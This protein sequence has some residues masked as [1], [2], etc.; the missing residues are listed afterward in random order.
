MKF[1]LI[2][3]VQEIDVPKGQ[4]LKTVIHVNFSYLN[5]QILL[6]FHGCPVQVLKLIASGL[7]LLCWCNSS[8]LWKSNWKDEL[9]NQFIVYN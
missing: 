2:Q 3:W 5:T 9:D 7:D 8:D 4:R 1:L 6:H